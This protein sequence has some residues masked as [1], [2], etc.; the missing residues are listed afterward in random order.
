MWALMPG[1]VFE[2]GSNDQLN[3]YYSFVEA[4]KAIL[5]HAKN[6]SSSNQSVFAIPLFGRG[7]VRHFLCRSKLSLSLHFSSFYGTVSKLIIFG[8]LHLTNS[9]EKKFENN[10]FTDPNCILS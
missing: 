10:L 9:I 5:S 8:Q 4:P 6:V 1:K 7:F 3:S 2:K